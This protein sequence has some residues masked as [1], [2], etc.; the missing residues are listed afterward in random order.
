M[1]L[2]V[3]MVRCCKVFLMEVVQLL[4]LA[5]GVYH[6]S[7]FAIYEVDGDSCKSRL[8]A[9]GRAWVNSYKSLVGTENEDG[10]ECCSKI[11]YDSH[12]GSFLVWLSSIVFPYGRST[13]ALTCG[14]VVE[15]C[16]RQ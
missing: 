9:C 13:C 3:C 11:F 16:F 1:R 8:P 5:G 4:W 10:T 12:E 14:A 6:R 2:V 7:N 15:W